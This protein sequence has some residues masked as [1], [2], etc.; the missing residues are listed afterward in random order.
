MHAGQHMKKT[1]V[2][3]GSFFASAPNG[4]QAGAG[5]CLAN[6]LRVLV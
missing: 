5:D 6:P 1:Q 3:T 2:L 4:A